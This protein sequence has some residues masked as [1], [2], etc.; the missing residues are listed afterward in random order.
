MTT[1]KW[2]YNT[3]K[4]WG[5]KCLEENQSPINIDTELIEECKDLCELECMYN[6]SPCK[7]EFKEG[8]NLRILYDSDAGILFKNTFFKLKEITVHTPSLHQID[9]NYADCEI[10]L[11]HSASDSAYDD[12]GVIISCLYNQGNY[13]GKAETFLN[14]FINTIKI[15]ETE[16]VDVSPDWSADML[17]PDKKSFFLYNG[18]LPFPPCSK[19]MNYIVMDTIG[20]IGPMNLS[21]LQN[22]LGKNIRPINT[23]DGRQVYYNSGKVEEI[24][25]REVKKSD[26][27]YLRCKKKPEHQLKDKKKTTYKPTQDIVNGMSDS[28]KTFVRNTLSI[29]SFT[30][31]LINAYFLTKYLFKNNIAQSIIVGIVGTELAGGPDIINQWANSSVCIPSNS[32]SYSTGNN[33]L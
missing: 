17:L 1:N 14:Q 21:L 15:N 24:T 8:Q 19:K 25:Y 28:N 5:N 9:G 6:P 27:K 4:E 33:V 29:I 23:L 26:N 22:N 20:N 7:V 2:S 16:T 10:C 30:I 3:P 13:Y 12:N 31:I 11:I 18:S 32:I